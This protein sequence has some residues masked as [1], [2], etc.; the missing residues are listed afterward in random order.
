M[1]NLISLLRKS[2]IADELILALRRKIKNQTPANKILTA[3]LAFRLKVSQTR[4]EKD[5][6]HL[7]D[8][9]AEILCT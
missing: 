4:K 1:P 6:A 3:R 2:G 9:I 8:L 7:L 5:P